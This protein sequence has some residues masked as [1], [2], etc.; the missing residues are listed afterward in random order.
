M[1]A[2]ILTYAPV[3]EEEKKLLRRTK[4]FKIA[5][6][7]HGGEYKPTVRIISDYVLASMCKRFPEN[8]ISIRDRFRYESKRVEYINDIEFKGATIICAVE[9]L[10]NNGYKRILIVGDNRVNNKD[11][12]KNVRKQIDK[13][14]DGLFL[15]QYTKGN[16]N[17]PVMSIT[18]FLTRRKK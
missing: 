5:I 2:I 6:N 17:L 7:Q 9:Y 10:K 14:K 3:K 1:K 18:E 8:I 16:F 11:F 12:Q 4:V 15:Y 13:I